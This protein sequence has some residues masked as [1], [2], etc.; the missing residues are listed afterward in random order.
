[1]KC[2]RFKERVERKMSSYLN[3]RISER[4][5]LWLLSPWNSFEI[6]E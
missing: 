3:I 1:M 4:N 6:I 5:K 2:A